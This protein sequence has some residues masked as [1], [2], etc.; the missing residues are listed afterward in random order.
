MTSFRVD[1]DLGENAL[2]GSAY[3]VKSGDDDTTASAAWKP[4]AV[5]VQDAHAQPN[6]KLP[7]FHGAAAIIRRPCRS[8]VSLL[9]G[10]PNSAPSTYDG[11]RPA[12]LENGIMAPFDW[13]AASLAGEVHVTGFLADAVSSS[14]WTSQSFSL[15][16]VARASA[17]ARTT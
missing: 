17:R 12:H 8:F 15:Q 10:S 2:A 6:R 1:Q 14:P 7:G 3:R 13:V 9:A 5:F 16:C 11:G 4:C